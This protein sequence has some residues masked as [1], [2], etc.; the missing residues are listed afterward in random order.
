LVSSE[1][2]LRDWRA[3]KTKIDNTPGV[4]ATAP[5]IQG[6]V[7][8]EFQNQRLAPLIRG[9]DPAQEEKVIPLRKFIKYGKLDLEGESAVLGIELARKLQARVGDKITVYSPGNLGQI[10]DS[11]KQLENAEGEEAKKAVDRLR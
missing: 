2:V 6:P 9:I 1:D 3:L 5:Y 7:I 4:V 10:L 8:V 11:I